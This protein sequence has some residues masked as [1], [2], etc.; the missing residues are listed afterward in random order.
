M[1]PRTR[2]VSEVMQAEVATLA[3]DERLDLADDVM[4]LGRVRHMPVLE[5]GRV[6]GLVSTRDTLAASLTKALEFDPAARRAFLRS[7]EVAEVMTRDLVTVEPD[8]TLREAAALMVQRKIGGLPVVKP[9]GTMVG[10][11]TE[12]DLL[13]ATLLGEGDDVSATTVEVPARDLGKKLADEFE[14]LRVRD[15]MTAD[16]KTLHRND[17]LSA[18]DELMK[19]GR[20][21]HVVVL[22]DDDSVAGVLSQRSIF[23][24]ALAWS[25][26]QGTLAHQKALESFAVKDVMEIDVVTVHSDSGLGEA[27]A[28]MMERKIGCL[29]VVDADRLVGILTEGDF[30]A[31]L[32]APQTSSS[33]R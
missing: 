25:L 27:A 2:R 31:M 33:E 6:V 11:L 3:P 5:D 20:F 16:V 17:K 30:L 4:R 22:D 32:T 9:D 26:G 15:L 18:A 8:A 10:L 28:T 7:V 14:S 24:G 19:L 29:P 23:Y 21:R 12:T 13:V 1:D